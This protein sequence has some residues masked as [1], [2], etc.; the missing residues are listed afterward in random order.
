MNVMSFIFNKEN[1]LNFL[2]DIAFLNEIKNKLKLKKT[3]LGIINLSNI[4][5]E[6]QNELLKYTNFIDGVYLFNILNLSISYLPNNVLNILIKVIEYFLNNEDNLDFIGLQDNEI[7]TEIAHFVASYF[8]YGIFTHL[9][10]FELVDN[11][12]IFKNFSYGSKSI[13]SFIVN[14]NKILLTYKQ[15]YFSFNEN[16]VLDNVSNKGNIKVINIDYEEKFNEVLVSKV[17]KVE[18]KGIKLE[19]AKIIVSGGRDL[20]SKE[21]FELLKELVSLLNG[22]VGA[23]RAAVDAGWIEPNLQIGQT[24]KT[25]S[26]DLYIA[27]GISGATQHLAGMNKS[28]VIVAIN[29]DKDAPI[30]KYS[31]IGIIE[32]Y[33][34]ILP[35]IIKDL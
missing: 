1:K 11:N 23:S 20:G 21:G 4:S 29:N 8:N 19:D 10:D 25:V 14:K 2:N 22:A 13:S 27:V 30:F 28:K 32:D 15:N 16:L 9:I 33:K 31:H 35:A 17:S 34:V 5:A 7:N 24:G 12:I 26:P 6:Y 18:N 3:F